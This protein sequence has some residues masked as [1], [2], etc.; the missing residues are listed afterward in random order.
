[1]R[2]H[3]INLES[4][5]DRRAYL[6]AQLDRSR[7]D[8]SIF[9]AIEPPQAREWFERYDE[10]GYLRN[11]GR[12]ASAGEIACF[13]SHAT[14]WK[15]AVTTGEPLVVLE[16][17]VE[18]LPTFPAALAATAR[19]IE[20]YGFI[21][22]AEDGPSR[23]VRT[24]PM[25]TAGE[26]TVLRYTRYPFGSQGYA[27]SPKTA[28]AFLAAS[29]VVAAPPDVFIKKFWEHRQVL[30]GLSPAPLGTNKFASTPVMQ[31]RVKAKLGPAA[32]LGRLASK[33]A[34]SLARARFNASFDDGRRARPPPLHASARSLHVR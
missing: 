9:R 20:S 32:R 26:F 31:L 19:L 13:A 12:T 28:A 15:R 17:D 2:V 29:A 27:I 11:T 24:I 33:L 23:H 7:V 18:I 4:S 5:G 3:V 14:L 1:M 21:R 6:C 10:K 22:F 8:Y 30:Y 16:D 25:E 34:D